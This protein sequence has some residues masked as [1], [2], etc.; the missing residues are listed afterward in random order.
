MP[1]FSTTDD[2]RIYYETEGFGSSKPVV[3]FLNGVMQGTVHWKAHCAAFCTGFRVLVYDARAQGQSDL[4]GQKLTLECHVA[5]LAALLEHVGVEKAHL[6]GLSHG[7]KV[8]LAFAANTPERVN[9]VVLCSVG[10]RS[11]SRGRLAVKS[12]LEILKGSGLP[13]MMRAALPLVFGENFLKQKENTLENI[14]QAMV[15]RNSRE[16]LAA[17]LEAMAAYPPSYRIASNFHGIQC[18]VMSGSDDPLVSEGEARR[19]AGLCDG[20][21]EKMAEVG[22]SF[23]FEAP[24]SFSATVR[25]FLGRP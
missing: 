7:A 10:A 9:R 5:D 13:A 6:V 25:A 19:L 8:A 2:C 11:T 4:G 24:E 22:H 20:R 16:A 21:Y 14:A 1:Y 17:Q 3:V 23:P 15:K 18:L 12:W